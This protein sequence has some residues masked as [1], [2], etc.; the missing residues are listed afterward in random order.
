[1][2]AGGA[3][4]STGEARTSAGRA[5]TS[6]S[7]GWVREGGRLGRTRWA[8]Q[9]LWT[10][11]QLGVGTRAALAALTPIEAGFRLAV[12]VRGAWYDRA[13]PV[14]APIPVISVGNLVAGGTG[15]SPVVRWLRE[16]YAGTGA[17]A[18][19]VCRGYGGD[20]TAMHRRWF[21]RD[22]VFT[23]P[24]RTRGVRRAWERGWEVAILDDGFQHRRVHRD[25]DILIAAA[26][27]PLRVRLLPRGPYREPLS[28][29]VRA[30]HV[31]V[32]RRTAARE[33]VDAWRTAMA[34][35]TPG[36]PVLQAEMEMGEWTDLDGAPTTT[37]RGD[38]LAVSAIARPRDFHT[39]LRELLPY[40][41]V[42]AA[43]FSDHHPYSRRDVDALLA[44]RA[45][46][47]VV[48]TEKDAVK[49]VAFPELAR[50]CVAVG[51][52]V[53]GEPPELLGA[54]LADAARRR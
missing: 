41:D 37:P 15:K 54:A 13:R 40:A 27:D 49:L 53:A 12:A 48:C 34:R 24:S 2:S 19:V 44:R 31:L 8:M 23:D 45:G 25:L 14:P 29:A 42:E 21:G 9:E 3:R 6:A 35:A 28:A 39:G 22:A 18:A 36:T 52:R 20:E 51:F 5:R 32:T 30:T 16:W 7:E 33:A 38:V 50:H 26:E 1:M 43:P 17:R 4:T 10:G 46:R 11:Q 47:T